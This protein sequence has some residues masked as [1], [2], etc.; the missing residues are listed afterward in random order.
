MRIFVYGGVWSEGYMMVYVTCH[1]LWSFYAHFVLVGGVER[2]VY[3]NSIAS[4]C[5]MWCGAI[6]HILST[7]VFERGVYDKRHGTIFWGVSTTFKYDELCLSVF[8]DS[9]Y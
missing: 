4:L 3:D 1:V 6:M 2:G 8:M 7:G 9:Y 5:V